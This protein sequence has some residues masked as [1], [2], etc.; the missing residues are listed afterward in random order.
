MK[1]I[2]WLLLDEDGIIRECDGS[3]DAVFGRHKSDIVARHVAT[4]LP[5]LVDIPLLH[6]DEPNPTLRLSSRIGVRFDVLNKRG[7]RFPCD[8][9]LGRLRNAGVPPL[10]LVIHRI[11]DFLVLK[12]VVA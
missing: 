3:C 11:N 2:A 1:D 10:R 5:E 12:P 7:E 6:D 8:I 9:F 4:L